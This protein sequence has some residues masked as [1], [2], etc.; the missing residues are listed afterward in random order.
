[1]QSSPES[2][3]LTKDDVSPCAEVARGRHDHSVWCHK[4]G[5]EWLAANPV[6]VPESCSLVESCFSSITVECDTTQNSQSRLLGLPA[7]LID[8][9]MSFLE[10]NDLNIVA[11]TCRGLR[12]H[13]Q[14][15]FKALAVEHMSWL[16]EVFEAERYPSSPDWPVTWDPCSP[17][18]LVVPGPPYNLPSEEQ[19]AELWEEIL[20]DDPHMESVRNTVKTFNA[21]RREAILGSHRA[22]VAQSLQEWRD[23][24]GGVAEW[25]FRR[26]LSEDQVAHDGLDWAR[27]WRLFN[28]VT[29]SMPGIRNRARIW[30]DC[31]RI[32]DHNIRLHK[33]GAM[34][35]RREI[36]REVIS[37]NREQW[38][39]SAITA[40]HDPSSN[41]FLRRMWPNE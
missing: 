40:R 32:L 38:W 13:T 1:M 31:E 3:L 14:L 26:P 33:Q 2:Y 5:D 8:H 18:G 9:I 22:R 41:G 27:L 10:E 6:E 34:D 17:P 24:R 12:H 16:W 39:N 15:F 23:F 36:V 20:K 29:T 19:E 4:P 21:L 30:K 28:P 35:S 25:I 11:A 37:Y 7:E